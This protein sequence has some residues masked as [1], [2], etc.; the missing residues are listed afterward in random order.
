MQT[1]FSLTFSLPVLI[2]SVCL[3]REQLL[4]YFAWLRLISLLLFFFSFHAIYIYICLFFPCLDCFDGITHSTA[5]IQLNAFQHG[6]LST[7]VNSIHSPLHP[8]CLPFPPSL[9]SCHPEYYWLQV[10]SVLWKRVAR[11]TGNRH[12]RCDYGVRTSVNKSLFS[13]LMPRRWNRIFVEYI[14][15]DPPAELSALGIKEAKVDAWVENALLARKSPAHLCR[16]FI[17]F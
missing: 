17:Y 11:E 8:S 15:C 7:A 9:P 1:A 6:K 2:R 14:R 4:I 12:T 13:C 10:S 16:Q 3:S 5:S